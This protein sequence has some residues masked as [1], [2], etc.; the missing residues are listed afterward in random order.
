MQNNEILRGTIRKFDH[1][2]REHKIDIFTNF[3]NLVYL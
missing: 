3:S 2:T 1:V